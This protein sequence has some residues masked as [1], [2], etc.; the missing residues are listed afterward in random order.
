MMDIRGR[1]ANIAHHI[2]EG[3]FAMVLLLLLV[4]DQTKRRCAHR[5][6]SCASHSIDM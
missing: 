6:R 2:G 3:R 5:M 4:F 1:F